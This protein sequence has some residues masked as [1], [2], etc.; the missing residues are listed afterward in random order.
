[1]THELVSAWMNGG[2]TVALV[3]TLLVTVLILIARTALKQ[4]VEGSVKHGFDR[5]T[6]ERKAEFATELE[7]H[8]SSLKNAEAQFAAQYKALTELR[9]LCRRVPPRKQA[10]DLEAEEFYEELAL[11]FSKHLDSLDA[12]LGDHEPA[13]P[14]SVLTKLEKAARISED[15]SFEGDYDSKTGDVGVTRKGREM[16]AEFYEVLINA[17]DEMQNH[18]IAQTHDRKAGSPED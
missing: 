8:K 14:K 16:A 4:W 2:I 6:Q 13:L 7:R 3:L 12:F 1:M 17:R 15:G 10:P 11:R 18:V 9:R 5:A